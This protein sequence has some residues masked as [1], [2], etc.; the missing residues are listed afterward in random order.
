ME[1]LNRGRLKQGLSF[2]LS[3]FILDKEFY[4]LNILFKIKL[5]LIICYFKYA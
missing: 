2:F 1:I 3:L 4:F 5:L